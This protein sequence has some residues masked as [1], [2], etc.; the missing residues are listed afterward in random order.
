[1]E[2]ESAW[3][4]KLAAVTATQLRYVTESHAEEKETAAMIG[5]LLV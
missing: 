5:T 2:P 1:M 4:L 3:A